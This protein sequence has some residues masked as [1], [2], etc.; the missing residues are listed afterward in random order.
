[1]NTIIYIIL[2]LVAGIAGGLFGIGGGAIIVPGLV[3]LLGF[4]QHQAQGTSL[5]LFV[6][7]VG[8][9]AAIRYW[10]S[11]N[12]KIQATLIICLGV[13]LGAWLGAQFAHQI[14][15]ITLKRLFGVFLLLISI[16]MIFTKG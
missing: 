11:G 12:V 4:T 10:Q 6:L 2:G 5:S 15:D 8:L 7:P 9:L 13:F 3:Y 1:M 14:S 16:K